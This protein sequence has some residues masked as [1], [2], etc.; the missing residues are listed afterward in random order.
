M[1]FPEEV[2]DLV[3]EFAANR[4]FFAGQGFKEYQV[5]TKF[6]S[7]VLAHLGW[8][9]KNTGLAPADWMVIEEDQ[10]KIADAGKAPDYSFLVDR[11]RKFYLEAKRPS[12]NIGVNRDPA[13]QIRRYSWNAGHAVGLVTDF[14]EWAVY[15][16]R[17]PPSLGDEPRVGRLEYFTFGEFEERWDWLVSTFGRAAVAGGSLEAF[18]GGHVRPSGTSTIDQTFLDEIREWRVRLAFDISTRNPGL[19]VAALNRAVQ[20]LI[21][22]IVF[23]RIAEARGLEPPEDLLRAADEAPGVYSRLLTLFLRA[24]TLYNSGLFR[25]AAAK[26]DSLPPDRTALGLAIG[27]EVL[28]KI[29]TRLYYPH[30]YEF[31]VMPAD[32][33]GRVY[34][35]FLGE[36][37]TMAGAKAIVEEKAETRKAGGVYYTPQPIVDYI[38]EETIGPLLRGASPKDVAGIKVVD[39]ACGSGSFLIVAYQYL[40]DWH[41][42]HYAGAPRLAKKFLE[43]GPDGNP[44]L[45]TAERRRILINSIYGVDIDPQAVEVTKLS[46]LLKVIEGQT[47][48]ELEVGRLLPNLDANIR[49]GNSLIDVDFSMPLDLDEDSRL[50]D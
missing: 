27:D 18:V 41:T 37:I 25:F 33:L 30:P 11:K 48:M 15:D 38:V 31:S 45:C 1:R 40:L 32:I 46:L 23:L 44:R 34:E 29:I 9:V 16:G 50:D 10:L 12:V 8:D 19:G 5:R 2:A 17:Y 24:D 47:E 21:D 20:N 6:L 4:S 13:Y 14:E 49:C 36:T 39:P 26:T 42:N 35:Q 3:A 7:P 43:V 28:R 22:R